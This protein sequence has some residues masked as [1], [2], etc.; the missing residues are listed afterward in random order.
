MKASAYLRTQGSP[1]APAM[2]LSWARRR[3]TCSE[4]TS[5]LSKQDETYSQHCYL[6]AP[7][8]ILSRICGLALPLEFH[9][10]P[11]SSC[12]ALVP[13]SSGHGPWWVSAA[14]ARKVQ[15]SRPGWAT[16]CAGPHKPCEFCLRFAARC[17][18]RQTWCHSSWLALYRAPLEA[19]KEACCCFSLS[20]AG[21][22]H[23]HWTAGPAGRPH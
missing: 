9:K 10:L 7:P 3:L 18:R 8:A 11:W 23:N 22:Q 6:S 5:T 1:V 17:C 19:L 13:C 21:P 15:L 20:C 14:L 16:V 2:Q 12:P 4:P